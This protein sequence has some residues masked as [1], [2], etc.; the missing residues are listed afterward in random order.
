MP[1]TRYVEPNGRSLAEVIGEIKEEVKEFVQTRVSMFAAEMR[2][3]L[4]NS[5]NGAMYAAIALLFGAVGFLV[6]TLALA[7]LVAA[8]FWGSP[9]AW[10][11]GFLIIGLLWTVVA[12]MLGI[13]AVRQFRDL[14]PKRTIQ[15]LKEDKIWLQNEARNQ[16]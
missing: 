10:F 5:K 1:D 2:E 8:A 4:N 14:A 13:A 15:V 12:A 11:F 16:I 3:K 7:A 6:L 9:Y